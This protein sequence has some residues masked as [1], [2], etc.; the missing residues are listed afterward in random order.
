MP[1][2]RSRQ[3]SLL[4]TP[5][6]ICSPLRTA[7]IFVWHWEID[8][9]QSYAHR[10]S[11]V[12]ERFLFLS[13]LFDIENSQCPIL[14]QLGLS[15]EQ[16]FTLSTEFEKHS[17]YAAGAEFMKNAYKAHTHHK[18]LRGMGRVEP[19]STELKLPRQVNLNPSIR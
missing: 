17:C 11:W 8:S 19:Y 5:I 18:R 13:T 4:D 9:G 15:A 6:T 2:P 7:F 12:E 10:R 1:Q 14:Q 3:V 16:W